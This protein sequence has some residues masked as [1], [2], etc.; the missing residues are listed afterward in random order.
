M[1]MNC[2]NPTMNRTFSLLRSGG[3]ER[4]FAGALTN[5]ETFFCRISVTR[6]DNEILFRQ[7]K[8]DTP[9]QPFFVDLELSLKQ[10]RRRPTGYYTSSYGTKKFSLSILTFY[11]MGRGMWMGEGL[12]LSIRDNP[13]SKD[14]FI[15]SQDFKR[16]NELILKN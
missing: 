12:P 4:S 7:K 8:I 13:R 16:I 14:L 5:F 1:L 11:L 10:L 2:T 15:I 3:C 9:I 6:F